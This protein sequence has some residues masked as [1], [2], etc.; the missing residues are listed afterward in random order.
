MDDGDIAEEITLESILAEY[1]SE[2][3]I[4][5]DKKTPSGI[6]SEKADRI[7]MELSDSDLSQAEVAS[8]AAAVVSPAAPAVPAERPVRPVAPATPEEGGAEPAPPGTAGEDV[9]PR[10]EPESG[11][12]SPAPDG[13]DAGD[14]GEPEDVDV[15]FFEQYQYSDSYRTP[16]ETEESAP[17]GD[18]VP[19]KRRRA[20]K[21][22]RGSLFGERRED[23]GDDADP[24]ANDAAP[25]E[26]EPREPDL[27]VAARRFSLGD[28]DLLLRWMASCL[29]ACVMAALTFSFEAGAHLPFGLEND[30]QL[31]TGILMILQLLVMMIGVEILVRGVYSIVQASPGVEFLVVMSNVTALCAGAVTLLR[32]NAQTELPYSAVGAFS[33]AFTLLGEKLYRRSYAE[34]IKAAASIQEPYIGLTEYRGDLNRVVFRRARGT[35]EGFYNALMSRDVCES[36]YRYAAPMLVA[37]SFVVTFLSAFAHGRSDYLIHAL[38]APLAAAAAFSGHLAFSAPFSVI[39]KRARRAGAA[40]TGWMCAADIADID[41]LCVTDD[42]LFPEGTVSISGV[43][44]YEGVPPEKAIRYTAGLISASGSGLT[45]VFNEMLRREGMTALRVDNFACY[46]GG[47]SALV[48][49]ERVSTGSAAYMKLMGIRIPAEMNL[50]SAVF[51]AVEDKLVAMFAMDYVPVNSVQNALL[52]IPRWGIRLLFAVQDFNIT[53]KMAEQKFNV[54]FEDVENLPI[55]NTYDIVR[56]AGGGRIAAVFTRDGLDVVGELVSGARVLKTTAFFATLI[57]VASAALGV[58]ITVSLCWLGAYHAARAGNLLLF[59]LSTFAVTLLVSGF[60]KFKK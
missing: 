37:F 39:S 7:I 46:D 15:R 52:S 41:G 56:G 53:T 17:S 55:R 45:R 58:L 54:A 48:H 20:G 23:D 32:E 49:G 25:V 6:L 29:T 4:D 35:A 2:A 19:G 60:A 10:R 44:I 36:A 3:Y 18:D 1:K 26:P 59:M 38:S 9:P 42:D 12:E 51:T 22:A 28:G 13:G 50:N 27:R 8:S 34:T 40:M 30:R 11:G 31:L 21:R 47:I 16:G 5:G 57:S 24:Y 43:K 14:A 33:V